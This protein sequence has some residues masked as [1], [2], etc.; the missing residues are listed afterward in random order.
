MDLRYKGF[1]VSVRGSSHI[2]EKKVCQDCSAYYVDEKMAIA[3]VCDGHGSD[4]H[5]RSDVG[6]AKAVEVGLVAMKKLVNELGGI[7]KV[8]EKENN[9]IIND[10]KNFIVFEWDSLVVEHFDKNPLQREEIPKLSSSA[11]K[12]LLSGEI[13][14]D[15]QSMY[16]T[17]FISMV[18]TPDYWLIMQLGDGDAIVLAN[19]KMEMPVPVDERLQFNLTTSMCNKDAI[20]NFRV[21]YGFNPIAGMV[22]SSDGVRNS[23]NSKEN[24]LKFSNMFMED[25]YERSRDEAYDELKGF[26]PKLSADGSGDDISIA[27][28]WHPEFLKKHFDNDTE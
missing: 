17:T 1:A 16:G 24:F 25:F 10:L 18:M 26:L 28:V 3:I 4:R 20:A 12:K 11:K 7:S 6:S 22:A 13:I 2:R 27:A 15:I 19:N 5:F 8:D 23:F 9:K 21:T 14:G